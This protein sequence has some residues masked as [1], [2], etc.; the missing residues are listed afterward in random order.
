M[1]NSQRKNPEIEQLFEERTHQLMWKGFVTDLRSLE[2][3][4]CVF[5]PLSRAASVEGASKEKND[6]GLFS[7]GDVLLLKGSYNS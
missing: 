2:K 1:K 7:N 3:T 6:T 5:L 4:V